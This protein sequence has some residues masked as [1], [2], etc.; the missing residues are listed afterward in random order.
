MGKIKDPRQKPSFRGDERTRQTTED[1]AQAPPFLNGGCSPKPCADIH[2]L[3]P[4]NR[5]L[6]V[7]ILELV[8][9]KPAEPDDS[10]IRVALIDSAGA[11]AGIPGG[12]P[13][14]VPVVCIGPGGH[15]HLPG[16]EEQLAQILVHFAQEPVS[17][18][19]RTVMVAG[20]HG[21]AGTSM[22]AGLLAQSRAAI[23]LDASGETSGSDTD[24]QSRRGIAWAD[25]KPDEWMFPTDLAEAFPVVEGVPVLSGGGRGGVDCADPRLGHVLR[26]LTRGTTV[27]GGE[28]TRPLSRRNPGVNRGS[29]PRAAVGPAR[30]I[31][32]DAGRWDRDSWTF[33]KDNAD[34][35]V[36]VG[37]G[38]EDSLQSLASHNQLFPPRIPFVLVHSLRHPFPLID[39]VI[40]EAVGVAPHPHARLLS[41]SGHATAVGHR[42]SDVPWRTRG[43]VR[44][45]THRL[46]DLIDEAESG[47]KREEE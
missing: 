15:L 46:W 16:E 36:L 7:P 23:L 45:R 29:R 37:W 28:K 1:A 11:H 40:N 20:W 26:A 33:H 14:G 3:S 25:L 41:R 35:L 44:R 17:G 27:V 18:R 32:I 9:L 21:G 19:C 22:L 4:H 43:R 30:R 31:I 39:T 13:G 47:D 12:I 34:V 6:V 8:G 38:D 5:Q 10:N 2:G 24:H 42:K